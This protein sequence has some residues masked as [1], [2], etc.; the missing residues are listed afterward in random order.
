MILFL[1]IS[2]TFY[3][4]VQEAFV[5][6]TVKE[7]IK[8]YINKLNKNGLLDEGVSLTSEQ[9]LFTQLFSDFNLTQIGSSHLLGTNNTMRINMRFYDVIENKNRAT[10]QIFPLKIGSLS[11]IPTHVHSKEQAF[12]RV[13]VKGI[14]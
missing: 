8:N 10:S 12:D 14:F 1:A 3:V 2:Y 13:F 4:N 5:K 11:T 6:R 7:P 9:D